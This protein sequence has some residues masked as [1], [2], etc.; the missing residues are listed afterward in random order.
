MSQVERQH[1]VYTCTAAYAIAWGV[2]LPSIR[3]ISALFAC[4]GGPVPIDLPLRVRLP[5]SLGS[6]SAEDGDVNITLNV[7]KGAVVS[8]LMSRSGGRG[9]YFHQKLTLEE[10]LLDVCWITF[11]TFV[12]A[13]DPVV[14]RCAVVVPLITNPCTNA[15]A[16]F[17]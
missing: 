17:E 12:K 8:N 14:C 15:G 2:T 4:F 7:L 9:T 10:S 16:N 11:F 6:R 1:K 5:R 13:S 3:C